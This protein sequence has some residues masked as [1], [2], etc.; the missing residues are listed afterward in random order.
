MHGPDE[1]KFADTLFAR[2]EDAL[3]LPRNTIKMGI[4]DEE[5]RTSVNLKNCIHAAK[6]R[7]VGIPKAC[8]ASLTMY[9]R[10]TGPTPALPSPPRE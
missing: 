6:A 10:S 9:S 3:S 1:V 7:V 2:V 4:M 8:I 5:R